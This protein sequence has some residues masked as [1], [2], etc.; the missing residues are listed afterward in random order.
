MTAFTSMLKINMKRRFCDGFAVGYNLIFPIIMIGL[1]GLLC[2]KNSYGGISSYQYYAVVMIPFCMIMAVVTAAY[3]GKDDAYVKTAQRILVTPVSVRA[4][5]WVKIISCSIVI[6]L[7]S[8]LVYA[9]A[10]VFVKFDIRS[11][12][13][14]G[15]LYLALAFAVAAIGTLIGLGMKNFMILKNILNIPIVLWAILGGTFFQIGT[16]HAWGN[17]LLNL[18]PVHW[19]NRSLFMLLYEKD[20]SLLLRVVIAL[21]AAGGICSVLAVKTFKKG[22]Y[23]NGDLPGYEE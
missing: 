3:A 20:D 2:K 13:L 14:A 7:C 21:A 6:F 18:S 15:L 9:G 10:C 16:F 1:L 11:I 22:E 4:I 5:V 19:I 23:M 17:L 8:M 12:G